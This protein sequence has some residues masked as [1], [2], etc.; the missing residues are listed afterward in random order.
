[1]AFIRRRQSCLKGTQ[2][3]GFRFGM[4]K[5]P[6]PDRRQD[7]AGANLPQPRCLPWARRPL[8]APSPDHGIPR[9]PPGRGQWGCTRSRLPRSPACTCT[10]SGDGEVGAGASS[11]Q[12]HKTL[13]S[14]STQPARARACSD[15]GGA[16]PSP[17]L[18]GSRSSAE[19]EALRG[20]WFSG[21]IPGS[22]AV[23][24]G[25]PCSLGPGQAAEVCSVRPH[26]RGDSPDLSCPSLCVG[27]TSTC[28]LHPQL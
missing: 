18:R 21:R 8:R 6:Y 25:L 12:K 13:S 9:C 22:D 28:L 5:D 24:R 17:T 14:P 10:G 27:G 1:M 11:H 15:P 19:T 26:C 16:S 7:T 4:Q 2:V 3:T 23:E 20:D